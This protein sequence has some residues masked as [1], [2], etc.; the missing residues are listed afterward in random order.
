MES[1]LLGSKIRKLVLQMTHMSGASHIGSCFSVSDIIAVLYSDT[2]DICLENWRDDKS[3][4]V[5]LSKGHAVAALYASLAVREFFPLE[6]L[7]GYCKSGSLYGG[8]PNHLVPGVELSTGSLGHGLPYGTGIALAKKILGHS[9]RIFVI[10][11]DGELDEGTTWESALFAQHNNLDNLTVIV[12]RNFLQSLEST[13]DTLKLEPLDEKFKS[14]NWEVDTIDGH[15]HT[16]LLNAL[17]KTQLNPKLIIAKTI[18]GKGVSFM[19]NEVKWHYKSPNQ[20]EFKRA[21][22]EIE[23]FVDL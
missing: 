11:S 14:F 5:I 16:E 20:E 4:R 15:N 12:D 19:E 7:E 10:M 23:G 21:F 17:T 22:E 1:K 6:H 8:H 2:F 13:E 18:K 9:G 3:N